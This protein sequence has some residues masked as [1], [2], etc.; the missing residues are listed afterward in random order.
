MREVYNALVREFLTSMPKVCE[1]CGAASPALV[2]DRFLKL[3]EVPMRN[4]GKQ[5]SAAGTAAKSALDGLTAGQLSALEGLRETFREFS[6]RE[7]ESEENGDA[8]DA[9]EL[10]ASEAKNEKLKFLPPLEVELRMR[11]LYE[12][13]FRIANLVWYPQLTED[14]AIADPQGHPQ[15]E[16]EGYRIFFVRTIL[17][18]PSRFRPPQHLHGEQYEHPQNVYLSN[19]LRDNYNLMQYGAKRVEDRTESMEEAA[20]LDTES[21]ES[22]E[23]NESKDPKASKA[24]EDSKASKT[25]RRSRGGKGDS[26]EK[27]LSYTFEDALKDWVDMQENYNGL[28]DSA[29]GHS[30]QSAGIRQLLEHKEGLFRMNMMGKRVNFAAR[31]V[32][33][34]DPYID[35]DE[36]GVPLQ[37]A[38]EL[39]YPEPVTVN[40]VKL[41]RQLVINGREKYP[42]ACYIE[43]EGG[44]LVDLQ[45]KNRGQREALAKTL[46][47]KD[48]SGGI[49]RKRVWRNL[50]QG[51]ILLVNRQPTLH[52]ASIMALRARILKSKRQTIRMHYSNCNTFNADFDGDEINLHF[53]QGELARSEA[54]NIV[55]AKYQ[56]TSAKDGSPLRGLI[57]DHVASGFLL[58]KRDTF[59][60]RQEYDQLVFTAISGFDES[61]SERVVRT[62]PPAILKPS[63]LWTG[64][65]VVSALLINL[66]GDLPQMT[67]H[68]VAQVNDK[69]WGSGQIPPQ[70]PLGEQLVLVEEGELL[71]GV[72]DKSTFGAKNYSLVHAIHEL[73][74]VDLCSKFLSCFGRVVT[75]YFQ[76]RGFTC[77]MEDLVLEKEAEDKRRALIDSA[78]EKAVSGMEQ[79][80]GL[81]TTPSMSLEAR[82]TAVSNELR[83]RFISSR[84]AVG[85]EID[86][87]MKSIVSQ[88]SSE[89]FKVCLP[90]G[91][92]VPFPNNSFSC[93][94][95][96]GAKGSNV[97]QTQVSC[98]LGQQEL[99]GRRVPMMVN[100]KTLPSFRAYDPMPRAGGWVSD[101]F[102][103]GIRPQEYY[104]HC[105]AGREGLVDTAVKTSRSGYLQRCIIKHLEDLT[106]QYDY[107][108]RN[109]D[110]AVIQLLYGDYGV[111]VGKVKYLTGK[112][113]QL[114]FL[115][116]NS[117]ILVYRYGLSEHFFQD[118]GLNS[119]E[120]AARHAEIQ[121]AREE[122]AHRPDV[123]SKKSVVEVRRRISKSQE[124]V[125]GNVSNEFFPAVITKV[126]KKDGTYDV[127]YSDTQ[128]KEKHVPLKA[129]DASEGIE[130]EL[131]HLRLPD[132][133]NW[134]LNIC[135]NIG[136]VN[137]KYQDQ[138]EAYLSAYEKERAAGNGLPAGVDRGG[139]EM[140]FWMKYMRSL[141]EPGD[142]VGVIAGQSIGEP[143]TQMTLNTFHL[144]GHGAVNV[145]L[146][147]PRLREIIMQAAKN[148]GTPM[149]T[150]PLLP[151]ATE[152]AANRLKKKLHRIGLDQLLEPECYFRVVDYLTNTTYGAT[153]TPYVRKYELNM[154]LLPADVIQKAYGLDMETVLHVIMEDFLPQLGTLMTKDVRRAAKVSNL[155]L[156]IETAISG[157]DLSNTKRV[158]LPK[159]QAREE[160]KQVRGT[161]DS[162]DDEEEG[163]EAIG[164]ADGMDGVR[165]NKGG[166][167]EYEEDENE[168]KSE[169]ENENENENE[170]ENENE[171]ESD[172]TG[173]MDEENDSASGKMEEE[174]SSSASQAPFPRPAEKAPADY[175]ILEAPFKV[176]KLKFFRRAM[177]NARDNKV[178][179]E[180][181]FSPSIPKL[182]LIELAE[183][184][185]SQILVNAIEHINRCIL[186]DRSGPD[187][188]L[189]LQTE[190][191]NF[192]TVWAHQGVVDVNK[193]YSNDIWQI[194]ETYG[195]E[196][197]RTAIVT[198][199][200][201]VFDVYSISV[202]P[203]H[204]TLIADYMTQD[205]AYRPMNRAGMENIE[206]PFQQMSFETTTHFLNNAILNGTSDSMVSPSA[207]IA[208]GKAIKAGTGCFKVMQP[209]S[210]WNVCSR[211]LQFF[212]FCSFRF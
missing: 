109:S 51:D 75:S 112:R 16:K 197:A 13:E 68:G 206:S 48:S 6:E 97:N 205:G 154:N 171:S 161:A 107:S 202:D 87:V 22:N 176:L 130:I 96:S 86:N 33:A 15:L 136:A 66:V 77:S 10:T 59:L 44:W 25:S 168:M 52:K 118:T 34:P 50:L 76:K 21:N 26:A 110:G 17:V 117:S 181:E 12:N 35:T 40:N 90:H 203:R 192:P 139:L 194:L 105:M 31:S 177:Y 164:E 143:A 61:A 5:L 108:V 29:K 163:D 198:E 167:V 89:I 166:R 37:F 99:E 80:M 210:V 207:C 81:E 41:L 38:K 19:I 32:I 27:P 155:E 211:N 2:R 119:Q 30:G 199:I 71:R 193:I 141:A 103:T 67:F 14:A 131:I 128:K 53:P 125:V 95:I 150:L 18:P 134:Q 209:L 92:R 179:V 65:Q 169:N 190:G 64:K 55:S 63:M 126:H 36:V 145:T 3:F 178:R 121:C 70:S 62:L 73:Y 160:T 157:K 98:A 174:P 28:V 113:A 173:K 91:L 23:L 57:Q 185:A 79:Y 186:M 165:L 158:R 133:V 135:R 180:F 188:P 20:N 123:L 124:W 140:L 74:G 100:G 138:L 116:Q 43:N 152:E 85:P 56:Y 114:D 182:L 129:F 132:P 58:T 83:Q 187:A 42:G 54:Y 47:V 212:I 147:I 146:G 191:V 49:R 137:E 162:E 144:A 104:F 115:A 149:M 153:Y 84:G 200:T 24:S 201:R 148:I 151:S 106:V 45:Y 88:I 183:K 102:L 78:L 9:N 46:L 69:A 4:K 82:R 189:T 208:T 60:N 39:C 101:R 142:S 94:I 170:H 93:M 1:N 156:D 172:S 196:A 120:A 159:K 11:L 111:D 127:V 175:T 204:L 7:I 195:V 184:A 72:L 8:E 122:L